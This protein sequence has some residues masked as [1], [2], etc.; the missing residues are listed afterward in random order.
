[1]SAPRNLAEA[2]NALAAGTLAPDAFLA[3]PMVAK[4]GQRETKAALMQKK[5]SAPTVVALRTALEHLEAKQR[6]A[7]KKRPT[8]ESDIAKF[9]RDYWHK[10]KKASKE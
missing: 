4:Y 8:K 6:P 1:M 7:T 10:A 9:A 5:E 3:H 2:V